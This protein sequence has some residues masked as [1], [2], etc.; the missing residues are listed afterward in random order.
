VQVTRKTASVRGAREV[1]GAR[2]GYAEIPVRSESRPYGEK[3]VAVA[4]SGA[5]ALFGTLGL[6]WAQSAPVAN[7]VVKAET[8]AV[9]SEARGGSD[10]VQTLKKG[11]A[12]VLGLELKIGVEKWCS[13][14]FP[15][16]EKL[17]FVAC[18]GLERSDKRAGDLALPADGGSLS[19][20]TSV[21]I[22]GTGRS[23]A[24]RLPRAHSSVEAS[25]E[26]R[27]VAAIVVHD[28]I[29]DGAKIAEFE[30]A[31]AGGGSDAAISRAAM[32]HDVAAG[33]ELD[34]NDSE[35]AIEQYR[36]ALP[37]AAKRPDILFTTM[38]DIAYVHLV[39]SE[40]SA[41]LEDLAQA[42]Q[43]V[44]NSATVAQLCGW[45]Y[46][47]LN[48]LDDA[49]REWEAAQRIAPDAHVASLLEAA[50]RDKGVEEGARQS[51]SSHFVLHYQGSAT[52]QLAN[53]ILR[54]LEEDYRELQSDLHFTP[55]E[56]IGVIL[57]TQQGFRDIT[58]APG[59]MGALNDGRI[60]V[61]V[62][63]LDSVSEQLSRVLKHE[64]THSFVRQMTFGRCPTWL[65]EGLAQWMEGR[66]SGGNAK[67]LIAAYDS[68]GL[69]P[70]QRLEGSWT[71]LP[72]SIAAFAYAWSLAA[73][74]C[75]MARSGQMAINRLLGDLG[76]GAPSEEALR[77][78]LQIGFADFARET[79][80]YLRATYPQ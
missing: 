45:A 79:A 77:E 10:V 61:P 4:M 80:D 53:D 51:E 50:R 3:F 11:D 21:I 74:E 24:V 48:R 22:G 6:C 46:S 12:L 2:C 7:T 34:H 71:A 52:P 35:Q 28:D 75:V 29:L 54:A 69:I 66:R 18:D 58:R 19:G 60:R 78:S 39:R 31:A 9:H 1:C 41:A 23:S 42:R 37:F 30:R 72:A 63:G 57:Y 49:I 65:Q 14:G 15:G 38:I 64:L 62:Q 70:L 17:G 55:P 47:G 32:A 76:T 43:V 33:F 73:V 27:R 56:S 59:W 68:G 67:F 13:V 40:Y 5:L 44:P 36:E 8:L 20:G 25:S 26:Y 16:Q